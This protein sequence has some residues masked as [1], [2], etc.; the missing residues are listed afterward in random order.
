MS[1]PWDLTNI[2]DYTSYVYGEEID[3]SGTKTIKITMEPPAKE[4]GK[5]RMNYTL[6]VE[7]TKY[8][9][10]YPRSTEVKTD[11]FLV[12]VFQELEEIYKS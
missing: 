4:E 6:D 11:G 2:Q 9:R 7:G 10:I 8:E 1:L 12:E 3:I 5:F